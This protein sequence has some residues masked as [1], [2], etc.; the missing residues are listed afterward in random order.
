MRS[1]GTMAPNRDLGRSSPRG[2]SNGSVPDLRDGRP[3]CT[4]PPVHKSAG[5][6]ASAL[7]GCAASVPL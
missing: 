3:P 6:V 4:G 5:T 7:V 2:A 1:G